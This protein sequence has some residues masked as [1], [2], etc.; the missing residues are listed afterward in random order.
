MFKYDKSLPKAYRLRSSVIE[1]ALFLEAFP[2]GGRHAAE[3]VAPETVV[4]LCHVISDPH[5]IEHS[6]NKFTRPFRN[7]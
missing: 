2:S 7:M 3:H 6:H 5:E 4:D 1:K